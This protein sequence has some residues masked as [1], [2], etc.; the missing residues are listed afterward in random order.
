[1]TGYKKAPQPVY[2]V[3]LKR[4]TK[5]FLKH[6]GCALSSMFPKNTKHSEII[7]SPV[8]ALKGTYYEKINFADLL[9]LY[10]C[11]QVRVNPLDVKK[12]Q[13]QAE[14]VSICKQQQCVGHV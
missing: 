11:F 4:V 5:S 2:S 3:I 7:I 8:D 14:Q 12:H 9:H 6:V 1:M 13:Q 10:L